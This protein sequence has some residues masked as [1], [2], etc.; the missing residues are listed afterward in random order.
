MSIAVPGGTTMSLDLAGMT[1]LAGSFG[2]STSTVNGNAAASVSSVSIGTDGTL[3]YQL[4]NGS[5]VAAYKIPL[6]NVA[7]PDNLLSQSGNVFT[8]NILSGQ[9]S[10]G[11]AG[12]AQ[13]GTI[14]SSELEESTVDI[15][16]EL[17]NMIVA[18]RAYEA[19]SQM[20][21]AGADLMSNLIQ[22][23]LT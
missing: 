5:T 3:S 2:V 23:N 13:L 14:N 4:S 21:K 20:F 12:T 17:T 9:V 7:S 16:T 18:Q 1:Q 6:A 8:P 11:T 19:N 10:V 22:M 15:A